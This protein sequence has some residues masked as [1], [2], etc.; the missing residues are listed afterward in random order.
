[1]KMHTKNIKMHIKP[2]QSLAML[3][4]VSVC[5]FFSVTFVVLLNV[6]LLLYGFCVGS[7]DVRADVDL[8]ERAA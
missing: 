4:D 8:L 5:F 3:N 1:M 2:E 7:A 6:S